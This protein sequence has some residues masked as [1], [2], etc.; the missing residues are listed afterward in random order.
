MK[1][2]ERHSCDSFDNDANPLDL[3]TQSLVR[4]CA[5]RSLQALKE[6]SFKI[7]TFAER[8]E[9][10]ILL[11]GVEGVSP[12][13][14]QCI[15]RAVITLSWLNLETDDEKY[16]AGK[17]ICQR[18]LQRIDSRWRTAGTVPTGTYFE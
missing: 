16:T 11:S 2:S 10:Q 4:V 17:L 13:V 5:E 6:T 15:Y 7:T 8:I 12:F 1:L 9:Q 3:E 14:L 18:L